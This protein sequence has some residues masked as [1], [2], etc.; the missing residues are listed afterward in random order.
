MPV[1]GGEAGSVDQ[2]VPA[3]LL[4]LGRLVRVFVELT[5][6]PQN[7]DK[8]ADSQLMSGFRGGL[9][10]AQVVGS[11][12]PSVSRSVPPL[13]GSFLSRATQQL[14]PLLG[15]GFRWGCL[16]MSHVSLELCTLA[17]VAATVQTKETYRN[18]MTD[19]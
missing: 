11:I 7:L 10:A 16:S 3:Q 13:L 15:A 6:F 8:D 18:H 12:F 19:V 14:S 1:V 5:L 2:T 9:V 17:V 4:P